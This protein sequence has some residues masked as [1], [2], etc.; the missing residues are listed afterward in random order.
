MIV[1]IHSS[2]KLRELVDV[3]SVQFLLNLNSRG[4]CVLSSPIVAS[5]KGHWML[6]QY[7]AFEQNFP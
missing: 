7:Y 6:Q 4:V 1:T 3:N 2:V 5:S